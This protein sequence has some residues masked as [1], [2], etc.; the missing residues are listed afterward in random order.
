MF[1]SSNGDAEIGGIGVPDGAAAHDDYTIMGRAQSVSQFQPQNRAS[2]PHSIAG[3][4]MYP[5]PASYAAEQARGVAVSGPQYYYGGYT[6]APAAMPY[7]APVSS[8]PTFYP[9]SMPPQPPPVAPQLYYN[10]E[11]GPQGYQQAAFQP[12]LPNEPPPAF[13]QQGGSQ[14]PQPQQK[15]SLPPLLFSFVDRDK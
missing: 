4:T 11:I 14:P 6:M 2:M 1:L 13:Y 15:E 5:P 10:P 9:V 3:A 7:S 12:P 8:A